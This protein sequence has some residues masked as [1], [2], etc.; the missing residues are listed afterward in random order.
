MCV[1]SEL[2]ESSPNLDVSIRED[3][4]KKKKI[5]F[6]TLLKC[7]EFTFYAKPQ[8]EQTAKAQG[9]VG[10]MFYVV[11]TKC[12]YSSSVRP[13]NQVLDKP[14]P[15]KRRLSSF[16]L[17]SSL[18]LCVHLFP[19]KRNDSSMSIEKEDPYNVSSLVWHTIPVLLYCNS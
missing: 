11:R 2:L 18:I 1:C 8:S 19:E 6:S 15:T 14:K 5:E 13:S 9:H 17:L 4:K 10:T 12:V 16:V 3:K 7:R